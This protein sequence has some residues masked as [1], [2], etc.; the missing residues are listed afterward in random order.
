MRQQAA[1]AALT[2]I[3]AALSGA[4]MSTYDL[5]ARHDP[6]LALRL[7]SWNADL[8]A[9][10]SLPLHVCEVVIRNAISDAI[11][12][13]YTS[14]WPWDPSFLGSL[15]QP[16]SGFNP[17]GE[18]AK[19]ARVQPSTGKVIAEMKFVFWQHMFT[20]R[21]I[22]RI[23][24]NQL[25]RIMPNLDPAR[26]VKYHVGEVWQ[27]LETIRRLRNRV[28]HHEPVLSRNLSGELAGVLELIQ[29]RC[30][31]TADW[32]RAAETLTSTLGVRPC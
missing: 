12:A 32:V 22:H 6:E 11:T 9:A 17:R 10:L 15:P 27:A 2:A 7:Y 28:A 3:R 29:S 20:N 26:P 24:N 31:L 8:S 19:V 16:R 4:R 5:A 1:P 13:A 30:S 23:W 14:R 25:F 21:H 18:L